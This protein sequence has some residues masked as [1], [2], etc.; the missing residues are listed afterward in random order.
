LLPRPALSGLIA[1]LIVRDTRA[2]ELTPQERFS[3]YPASPLCGVAWAPVGKGFLV[4]ANGQIN[5]EPVPSVS[6][7]GSMSRPNA[8]WTDGPAF[9]AFVILFPDAWRTLSGCE[10][11]AFRERVVPLDE[12]MGPQLASVFGEPGWEQDCDSA[13]ARLQDALTPLWKQNLG[14]AGSLPW[15][16]DWVRRLG[17]SAARVGVRQ[18]QRRVKGW[19]G[20]AHRDLA[21]HARAEALFARSQREPDVGFAEMAAAMGYA[22]QSHMIREVKRVTGHPPARMLELIE[23]DERL[24]FYRLMAEHFRVV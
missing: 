22:D 7:F 9:G 12:A 10:A 5:A 6:F 8:A 17:A 14:P 23:T 18:F 16:G 19:T 13:F 21:I 3:F 1:C 15:L 11:G 24:W 2:L 20:R 4:D